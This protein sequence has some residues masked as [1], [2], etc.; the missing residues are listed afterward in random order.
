M[1]IGADLRRYSCPMLRSDP[2]FP[3]CMLAETTQSYR[4]QPLEDEKIMELERILKE[5]EK[6]HGIRR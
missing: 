5:A 3:T 6:T 2:I 1:K 4:P